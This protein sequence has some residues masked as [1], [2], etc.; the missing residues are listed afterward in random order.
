MR[1][2]PRALSAGLV[3]AATLTLAPGTAAAAGPKEQAHEQMKFGVKAA[4]RGYWLEALMRFEHANRM[5]PNDPHILNN[6][7]VAL[8]AAGRF[9]QALVAYQSALAVAPQDRTLQRN[10]KF[11][12]EFYDENVAQPATE[13]KTE[14]KAAADEQEQGAKPGGEDQHESSTSS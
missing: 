11:F 7:A 3:V 5:T 2:I 6:I 8:E 12:K 4:N 9:E 14:E 1:A 10:Y 13:E